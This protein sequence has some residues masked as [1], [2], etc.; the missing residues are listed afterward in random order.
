[1]FL[2]PVPVPAHLARL[3]RLAP[4]PLRPSR[5]AASPLTVSLL[6]VLL[7]STQTLIRPGSWISDSDF[8]CGIVSRPS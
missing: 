7:F 1:L 6:P 2:R 3:A 5:V 4:A 8:G